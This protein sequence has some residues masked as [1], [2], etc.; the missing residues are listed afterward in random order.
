MFYK[1]FIILRYVLRTTEKFRQEQFKVDQSNETDVPKGEYNAFQKPE[2]D[3]NF[4]RKHAKQAIVALVITIIT[5]F[6]NGFAIW[7]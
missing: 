6:L 7:K 4:V 3:T 5:I 1:I 2:F